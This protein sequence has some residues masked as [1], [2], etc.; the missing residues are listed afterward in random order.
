MTCACVLMLLMKVISL[1]EVT[2]NFPVLELVPLQ[3]GQ[4]HVIVLLFG[5]HFRLM[6]S[7]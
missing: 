1:E 4:T 5:V 3:T 6:H 7:K 2:E